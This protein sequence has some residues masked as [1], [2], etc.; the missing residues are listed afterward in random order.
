MRAAFC[1]RPPK[2]ACW[3]QQKKQ[4]ASSMGKS[5]RRSSSTK[6]AA[7]L[8]RCSSRALSS[9]MDLIFLQQGQHWAKER[10][11][12]VPIPEGKECRK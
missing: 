12:M 10:S 5:S 11:E 2:R 6:P 9:A 7:K 1:P 3:Q 4:L 8:V